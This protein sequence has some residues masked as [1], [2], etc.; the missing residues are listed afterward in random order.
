MKAINYVNYVSE[1]SSK[2]VIRSVLKFMLRI[3]PGSSKIKIL[4]GYNKGYYWI[5][6][7]G[8][9][10]YWVGSFELFK[11][12]AVFDYSKDGMV[13]YDIGA[14]VGFYT[15]LFA[16][17]CG[18]SGFVY[19]FEPNPRNLIY[20]RE[21]LDMNNLQNV[22]VFPIALGNKR[23]YV[24]LDDS[25]HS[26]MGHLSREKTSVIVSVDTVDN[27]ISTGVM[28]P[29]DIIKIDVEGAELD[30]IYGAESTLRKYKPTVF[31]AIDN[32]QNE[33][34]LWEF[35]RSMGY[36]VQIIDGNRLEIIA[37]VDGIKS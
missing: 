30:V 24:F 4:T 32:P 17:L 3:I 15:L 13:A 20:I 27:L 9:H 36:K 37:S 21:H 11:Q 31:V 22:A 8:L 2:G 33:N 18:S 34:P 25:V 12:K 7:S 35:L 28:R 29:P 10:R 19:T 6:G 1:I 23:E 16:R 5:L 14:H 26:A